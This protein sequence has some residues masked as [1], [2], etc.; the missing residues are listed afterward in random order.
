M[1]SKRI[2]ESFTLKTLASKFIEWE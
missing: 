2:L 1:Q